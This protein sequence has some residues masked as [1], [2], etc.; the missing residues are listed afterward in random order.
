MA[1]AILST[2]Y[3]MLAHLGGIIC[4]LVTIVPL[5][6]RLAKVISWHLINH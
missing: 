2:N 3:V 4:Y 1:E 5:V 6:A